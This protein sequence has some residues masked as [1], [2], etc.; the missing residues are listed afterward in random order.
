MK[1]LSTA[2]IVLSSAFMINLGCVI[3][4]IYLHVGGL[5]RVKAKFPF[6]E[7]I[8]ISKTLRK[9]KINASEVHTVIH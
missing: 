7:Q 4:N 2:R 5:K 3:H 1:S 6:L 8:S 9:P